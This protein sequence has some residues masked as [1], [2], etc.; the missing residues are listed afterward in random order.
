[1]KLKGDF[2]TR[3]GLCVFSQRWPPLLL[4]SFFLSFFTKLA[5]FTSLTHHLFALVRFFFFFLT[6]SACFTALSVH[7]FQLNRNIFHTKVA[8][9]TQTLKPPFSTAIKCVFSPKPGLLYRS[10][11]ALFLFSLKTFFFLNSL[12]NFSLKPHFSL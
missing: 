5:I 11:N 3:V 8:S 1:M 7:F 4:S 10:L 12:L 2:R 6:N 9:F